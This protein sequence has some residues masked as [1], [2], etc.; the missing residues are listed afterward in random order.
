MG[1]RVLGA[2]FGPTGAFAL[3]IAC[4]AC[5]G[6]QEPS[7]EGETCYRDADCEVGLVCVP[8]GNARTCSANVGGLVSQV[9][10]PPPDA[11]TPM[12]D[13]SAPAAE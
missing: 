7:G 3:A 8:N 1:V 13:G 9:E 11:G 12:D 5:G 2:R 6:P 10:A 4:A